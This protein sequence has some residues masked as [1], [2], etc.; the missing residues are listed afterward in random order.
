MK[1]ARPSSKGA[2]IKVTARPQMTPD[3]REPYKSSSASNTSPQSCIS[4]NMRVKQ[5][6]NTNPY[7]TTVN[8]SWSCLS[9]HY[10]NRLT[11]T[12]W[13][14]LTENM[15]VIVVYACTRALR[16]HGSHY[17]AVLEDW[18]FIMLVDW[19]PLEN[20]LPSSVALCMIIKIVWYSF[21]EQRL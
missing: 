9:F 11:S 18:E 15:V 19:L 14:Y 8:L 21:H 12:F 10:K 5:L 7:K 20:G 3:G 2:F 16:A 13:K 1:T 4:A 17:R 6:E